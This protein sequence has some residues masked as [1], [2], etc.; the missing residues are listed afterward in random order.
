MTEHDFREQMI[1]NVA[2]LTEAVGTL[3]TAV[4]QMATELRDDD[5]KGRTCR[6]EVDDSITAVRIDL[7]SKIN[8][9]KNRAAYIGG[10]LG[11][12]GI[13]AGVLLALLGR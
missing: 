11:M 13:V 6:K 10:A 3:K 8:S 2:T 1:A 12:A 5:V 4:Q 9:I 7:E